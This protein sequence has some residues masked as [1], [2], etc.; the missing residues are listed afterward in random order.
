M[1]DTDSA[2]EQSADAALSPGGGAP[3]FAPAGATD[4]MRAVDQCSDRIDAISA[5]LAK[6]QGQMANPSQGRYQSAFQIASTR[7]CLRA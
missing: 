6:A 7:I 2:A 5:A 3:P 1:N 4:P